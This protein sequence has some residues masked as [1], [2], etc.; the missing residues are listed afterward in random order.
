MHYASITGKELKALTKIIAEFRKENFN[1][2]P[3]SYAFDEAAEKAYLEDYA[4]KPEAFCI[5]AKHDEKVIGIA[6]GSTLDK[7]A[8]AVADLAQCKTEQINYLGELIVSPEYRAHGIGGELLR[9]FELFSAS[10]NKKIITFVTIKNEDGIHLEQ[11]WKK[12]GYAKTSLTE[13]WQWQTHL[14][15]GQT[16]KNSHQLVY[17]IKQIT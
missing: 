12:Q 4:S 7:T 1:S 10:Q 15:D 17:W 16:A 11:Y 8:Q 13:S 6:T 14:A 9:Q 2:P 3:Y 5:V